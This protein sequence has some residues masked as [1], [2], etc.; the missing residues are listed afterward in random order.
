MIESIISVTEEL[1]APVLLDFIDEIII[2]FVLE[3]DDRA[4]FVT[5]CLFTRMLNELPFCWG[6][7]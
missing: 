1:G 6:R 3:P 5:I 4:F 2:V 7:N